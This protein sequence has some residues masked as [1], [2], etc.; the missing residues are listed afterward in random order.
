MRLRLAIAMLAMWVGAASAQEFPSRQV[1]IMV[2]FAAG[3]PSDTI[4][5]ILAESMRKTLGQPVI[6]ENV[7]G[8]AGAL[9]IGRVVNA[10]PDGYTLSLGNWS[11]HVG[12]P[13]ANPGA[14]DV[15]T[16]LVPVARLPIAPLMI[17]ARANLPAQDLRELIAWL[18]V[19]P[20][21]AGIVGFGSA[22]HVSGLYFQQQTGT[23]FQFV[24]YRGGN[25]ATQDLVA[26]TID[27]RLGTEA[28]QVHTYLKSGKLK[29]YAMLTQKRW[30]TAPEI[31]TIG[32]AGVAGLDISLWHGLWAPK[33]T[34]KSAIDK[35]NAAVAEAVADPQV[36]QRLDVLGMDVPEPGQRTAAALGAFHKAEIAKWW[37]VIKAA[38]IKPQ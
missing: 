23:Q 36:V 32:E 38:N 27:L 17:A 3:G 24:P 10:A 29:A 1:T 22:S 6:I 2:G 15:L 13:G 8:A 28:S 18:K 34:P 16:D 20:A 26:G 35:I 14:F 9:A 19:N 11:S 5:R 12:A 33:G 30:R 31:P 4:A 21:T 37:P 7:T 25:L